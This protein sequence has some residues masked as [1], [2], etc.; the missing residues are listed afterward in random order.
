MNGLFFFLLL[1]F[2]WSTSPD[3]VERTRPSPHT[4]PR[5]AHL[6]GKDTDLTTLLSARK[7]WCKLLLYVVCVRR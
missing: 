4:L 1:L 2:F 3:P 6:R 5:Y 7:L